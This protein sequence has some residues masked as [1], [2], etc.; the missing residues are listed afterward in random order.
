MRR[1]L[2][3][4]VLLAACSGPDQPPPSVTCADPAAGCRFKVGEREVSLRFGQPITAMAPF[5]VAVKVAQAREVKASFAMR[6]MDMG[7][8]QYR[9]LAANDGNWAAKVMLPVCVQGRRDW[10]MT[11]SVDGEAVTV[12]FSS[13]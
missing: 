10:L 4:L 12:P 7:S 11:L 8:N 5:D 3:P 9:L 6:G 2:A 1:W 13:H